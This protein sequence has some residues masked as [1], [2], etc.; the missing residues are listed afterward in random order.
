[1]QSLLLAIIVFLLQG[2]QPQAMSSIEG[3][4][5]QVGTSI[6]VVGAIVTIGSGRATTDDAGRFGFAN[7]E[8]G[9][10]RLLASHSAYVPTKAASDEVTLGSGQIVKDVVL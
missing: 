7:L 6:P 2:F 8:P 1:M 3:I 9:R 4:V 5:V 10:Y